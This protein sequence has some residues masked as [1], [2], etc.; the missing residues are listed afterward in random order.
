MTVALDVDDVA[1]Y[2]SSAA[3]GVFT[4]ARAQASAISEPRRRWLRVNRVISGGQ[5]QLLARKRQEDQQ[6]L[7][8]RS[9]LQVVINL[10]DGGPVY[11]ADPAS[12][13]S[14]EAKMWGGHDDSDFSS[15]PGQNAAGMFEEASYSLMSFPSGIGRTVEVRRALRTCTFMG[16]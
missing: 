4:S 12:T 14:I 7:G 16:W 5:A 1:T 9:V 6:Y 13:S 2:D 11:M 15:P 10:P 3:D 8:P